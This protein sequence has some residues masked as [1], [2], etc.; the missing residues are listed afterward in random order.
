MT[1]VLSVLMR[2]VL[3]R[4][5]S[6][7]HCF[8]DIPSGTMS[9][10]WARSVIDDLEL[11]CVPGTS[12]NFLLWVKLIMQFNNNDKMDSLCRHLIEF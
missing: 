3:N 8:K 11:T 6:F 10:A 2:R 9:S 1:F 7:L 4:V 12:G 5:K